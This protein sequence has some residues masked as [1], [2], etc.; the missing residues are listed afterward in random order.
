MSLTLSEILFKDY[1][2]RVLALLMLNPDKHY[3]VREIAR[4]TG[5]EAGTLHKELARL[6]EAGILKKEKIGNQVQY[7][8]DRQCP[9]SKEL[10][11]ILR[12]TSGPDGL[13]V[14]ARAPLKNNIDDVMILGGEITISRR[15]LKALL[16][17]HHINRLS[18]FGS[19]A[20]GELTPES[21]IDLLVEFE[22]GKSPSLGGMV[23][24]SDA[25]SKLF[26]G[27]KVDIAT[28]A[29]FKNPYRRREIEKEMEL[30]YAA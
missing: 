20:R 16:K 17:K 2:K 9:I 30:L 6:A 13:R 5:T 4:L 24:V 25:F 10:S 14:G 29:I 11:S 15:A 22:E 26:N 3:H 8:A 1:R 23:T 27:R 21:D 19:A 18:L 12:K 7:S 28:P